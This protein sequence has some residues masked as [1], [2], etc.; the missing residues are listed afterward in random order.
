[1]FAFMINITGYF[2]LYWAPAPPK[3]DLAPDIVKEQL[4]PRYRRISDAS[5]HEVEF[6]CELNEE[7]DDESIY[8]NDD[9]QEEM[10]RFRER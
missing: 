2:R 9:E 10:A 8:E 1:M 3:F 5:E 6:N 7:L 4:I